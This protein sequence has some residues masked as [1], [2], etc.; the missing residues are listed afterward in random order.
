[1]AEH[2][3]AGGEAVVIWLMKILNAIVELE[4]VPEVLKRGVVVP[5]YK[6]G[7]KDPKNV[8]SYRGITLTSMN[9]KVLEFL[10]LEQLESVFLEVGLPHVN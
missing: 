3:K 6:G 7:R 4:A 1:M 10:L 5:V 2:L 8:D 9:S